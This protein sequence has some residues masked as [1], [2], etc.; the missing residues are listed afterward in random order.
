[1]YKIVTKIVKSNFLKYFSG[2]PAKVNGLLRI[3]PL[4]LRQKIVNEIPDE[5]LNYDTSHVEDLIDE[6]SWKMLKTKSNYIYIY[7]RLKTKEP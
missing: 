5:I 1:M 4:G 2:D 3:R 7:R 6:E